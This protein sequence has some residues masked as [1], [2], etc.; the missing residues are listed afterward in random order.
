MDTNLKYKSFTLCVCLYENDS[1]SN[2]K[3]VFRGIFRN[4][5]LPS[6]ILILENGPLKFD[7]TE[8]LN[9][10]NYPKIY[11]IIKLKFNIGLADGFNI[12][13]KKASNDWIIKQ[14]A[15]D[16]SY[17][18]RFAK[19]MEKANE[20]YTLCGSFMQEKY[21]NY[22]YKLNRVVPINFTDIKKYIKYRNPFNNPT[23][24]LNKKIFNHLSGYPSINFKEDYALWILW[25]KYNKRVMNIPEILVSSINSDKLIERRKKT[26]S[27][28]NE[29]KIRK[30]LYSNYYVGYFFS[31]IV[32]SIR[33]FF[34]LSPIKILKFLYLR[35]LRSYAK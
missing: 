34:F 26:N 15:D 8:F 33:M 22:N 19:L 6:E 18:N 17:R 21:K 4:S 25:L 16:F 29:L 23:V 14:D 2:I 9:K 12:L 30:L 32:F 5:I 24:L 35:I 20:G 27:F 10:S 7:L 13:V 31:W 11:K 3:L 28:K 1:L